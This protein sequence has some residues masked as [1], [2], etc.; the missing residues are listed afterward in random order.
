MTPYNPI[1]WF[2]NILKEAAASF[3]MVENVTLLDLF[4]LKLL[5]IHWRRLRLLCDWVKYKSNLQVKKFS[6]PSKTLKNCL[7]T[8]ICTG[9]FVLL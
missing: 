6:L 1:G 8:S 3:F 5:D 4:H 2:A 9:I 7:S